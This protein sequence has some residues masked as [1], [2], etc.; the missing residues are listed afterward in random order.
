MQ[1]APSAQPVSFKFT[2]PSEF[3]GS[4]KLCF[5]R[6]Q[7]QLQLFDPDFSR[8]G[9][10]QADMFVLLRR[11]LLLTPNNRLQLAMHH[12]GYLQN[13]CPRFMPFFNDFSHAIECRITPRNLRQLTDSFCIADDLHIVRRYHCDHFRGETV[14][15]SA[16]TTQLSAKRFGEIREASDIGI[17]ASRLG[18]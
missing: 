18:L 1:S 15:D 5:E 10:D 14:F 3:V 16:E 4:L 13:E 17:H 6:A 12:T 8:W 7:N 11:F 9:L 2:L